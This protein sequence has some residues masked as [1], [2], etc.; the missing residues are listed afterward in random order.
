MKV[1]LDANVIV[2]AFAAHGLCEAVF[3]V[4]L[5]THDIIMSEELIAEIDKNLRKKVKLPSST[6]NSI[7]RL[8]RENSEFHQPSHVQSDTCRDPKDLHVLGLAKAGGASCIVTGDKD[9]LTLRKFKSCRILTPRQFS[10]L[11]HGK[12]IRQENA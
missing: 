8:L 4:C 1:L 2:A 12:R 3:E 5:D 11:I 6:V 10:D 7:T 9:L